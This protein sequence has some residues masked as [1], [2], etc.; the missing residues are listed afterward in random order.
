MSSVGKVLNGPSSEQRDACRARASLRVPD[1]HTIFNPASEEPAQV[2]SAAAEGAGL[3]ELGFGWT[4]AGSPVFLCGWRWSL[5]GKRAAPTPPRRKAAGTSHAHP[6][7][8]AT[9]RHLRPAAW[10]RG[11]RLPAGRHPAR[12]RPGPRRLHSPTPR[13]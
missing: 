10:E 3:Q 7:L 11:P 1:P 12:C 9:G 5:R 2:G 6:R 13:S 4:A 8:D